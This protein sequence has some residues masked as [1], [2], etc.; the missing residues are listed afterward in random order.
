MSTSKP[1]VL[2]SL[3]LAE[4]LLGEVKKQ[5]NISKKKIKPPKLP[6]PLNKE[7]VCNLCKILLMYNDKIS[8]DVKYFFN[9]E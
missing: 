3:K 2:E 4:T 6:N 1:T 9:V 8:K 5:Q 7:F